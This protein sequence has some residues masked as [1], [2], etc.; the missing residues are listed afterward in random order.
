MSPSIPPGW[1]KLNPIEWGFPSRNIT[2]SASHRD[3]GDGGGT[4][5]RVGSIKDGSSINVPIADWGTLSMIK[6]EQTA[7]CI[8]SSMISCEPISCRHICK[9]SYSSVG[10]NDNKIFIT[11]KNG[12]NSKVGSAWRSIRVSTGSSTASVGWEEISSCSVIISVITS[13]SYSSYIWL[14]FWIFNNIYRLT[15]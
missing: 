1:E 13:D 6:T 4:D 5:P 7:L 3:Q 15:F 12:T 9:G 8:I 10:L 11:A 2:S 14:W